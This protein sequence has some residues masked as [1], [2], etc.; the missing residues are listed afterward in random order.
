MHWCVCVC[1]CV[2]VHTMEDTS[3]SYEYC[4]FVYLYYVSDVVVMG[5]ANGGDHGV[6]GWIKGQCIELDTAI[7]TGDK[8][9]MGR[10]QKGGKEGWRRV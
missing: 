8:G 7:R 10:G 9:L 5:Y 4:V 3:I 1:V 2:C 6:A